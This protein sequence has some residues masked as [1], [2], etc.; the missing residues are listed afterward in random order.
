MMSPFFWLRDASV[1]FLHGL[2]REMVSCQTALAL[3]QAYESTMKSGNGN[4]KANQKVV[5]RKQLMGPTLSLAWSCVV[6]AAALY[7]GANLGSKIIK[8]VGD[9]GTKQKQSEEDK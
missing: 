3:L 4:P 2:S 6:I 9:E 1:A 7:T 8:C 5:G